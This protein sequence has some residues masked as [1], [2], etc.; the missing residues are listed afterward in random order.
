MAESF[1]AMHGNLRW[2]I[3]V[4]ILIRRHWYSRQRIATK[5]RVLDLFFIYFFFL[6]Y[7]Y[8]FN[9]FSKNYHVI[10]SIAFGLTSVKISSRRTF[11]L[12]FT[13]NIESI[14]K[15]K[16]KKKKMF[17]AETFEKLTFRKFGD[18]W[19]STTYETLK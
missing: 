1:C 17:S 2:V 4:Y 3:L 10:L 15:Q 12:V 13:M 19:A 7:N 14:S 6:A 8:Y 5:F 18:Y 16:Q 9:I 11:Y